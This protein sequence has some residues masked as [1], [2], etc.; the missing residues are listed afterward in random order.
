ML[1]KGNNLN[2][3]H[4]SVITYILCYGQF[5]MRKEDFKKALNNSR[6]YIEDKLQTLLNEQ[7]FDEIFE[8]FEKHFK[9][10]DKIDRME[11]DYK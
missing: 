3:P 8:M 1:N 5:F 4:N 10:K 11:D 6:T 7:K 2:K 9:Y